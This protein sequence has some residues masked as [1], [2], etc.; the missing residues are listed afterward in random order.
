MNAL[1]KL[2]EQT[3]SADLNVLLVEDD[4]A[5]QVLINNM[6]TPTSLLHVAETGREALDFCRE[7]TPDCVLMDMHLPQMD[8]LCVFTELRRNPRMRHVP[9][10][11]LTSMSDAHAATDIMKAG[12]MDYMVK[13]ELTPQTLHKAIQRSVEHKQLE[14]ALEAER[15]SLVNLN[16]EL[17]RRHQQFADYWLGVSHAMMTHLSS[18]QEFVSILMD[19]IPGKLNEE[20]GKCL[21]MAR[22]GCLDLQRQIEQLIKLTDLNEDVGRMAWDSQDLRAVVEAAFDEVR[23]DALSQNVELVASY[24]EDFRVFADKYL[25]RQIAFLLIHRCLRIAP[26]DGEIHVHCRSAQE[27]E[28]VE[29]ALRVRCDDSWTHATEGDLL[30]WQITDSLAAANAGALQTRQIPGIGLEFSF[31]MPKYVHIG[32]R[33]NA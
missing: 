6:L 13:D 25:L 14:A 28:K 31:E 1:I 26:P 23:L 20:Q 29:L 15:Q 9:F 21:A 17:E 24:D 4:P 30:G 32:E 11:F 3:G 16:Q 12:A 18:V 5:D 8:G 33:D 2:H 27:P 7:E 22:G 19:E 10:I